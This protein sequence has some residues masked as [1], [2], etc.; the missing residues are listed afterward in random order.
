M[1]RNS[2]LCLAAFVLAA[3]PASA[4]HWSV[5]YA[6]SRLSFTAQWSGEPFSAE[7]KRWN[8][9]IDFDPADLTH[10]RVSVSVDLA[11]EASDEADFD[12]GLKGAEGFET[13]HFPTA[14]FISKAF[15]AKSANTYMATGTLT[16]RGISRDITLPFKLAISGGMAHMTG[17]VH[18]V[19]TDFGIGQGTWAAPTP[20]SHDVTVTIDLTATK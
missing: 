8:A 19:R 10:A 5:D 13:S 6:K 1:K 12:S 11:S 20:V 17:T 4:A 14:R 16:V 3:S 7:F 15:S 2:I 9:D 18:V